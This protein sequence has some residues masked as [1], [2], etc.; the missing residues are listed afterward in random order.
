MNRIVTGS[1]ILVFA[2][3][4]T[5]IAFAGGPGPVA[6][7]VAPPAPIFT[8]VERHAELARRRSAVAA[9]MA[10]KSMLIMFSTEPK[11]YTNDVDY[12]YRQEND[13]Y[14]LTALKQEGATLVITKNGSVVNEFLFVPKPDPSTETW[15]GKMYTFDDAARVSGV[16][17]VVN[18]S[19]REA[20]LKAIRDKQSFDS[21]DGGIK[22]GFVPDS[23]YM[24]LPE[25]DKDGD[26][27]R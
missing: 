21:A 11:L 14:Y 8:E 12:V 6:P 18:A 24:L 17:T 22:T 2:L 5:A 1:M 25:S 9:K 4:V 16:R 7:L 27:L 10:D 26:G 19:E 23:I 20:F 13:L 3:A 15:H